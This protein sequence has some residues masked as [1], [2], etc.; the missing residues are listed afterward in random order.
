MGVDELAARTGNQQVMLQR[1][2]P[3]EHRVSRALR[4]VA[5]D[6]PCPGSEGQSFGDVAVA[7][8]ITDGRA[9]FAPDRREGGCDE[10]DAIESRPGVAPVK[11][12]A[13]ADKAQSGAGEC[14]SLGAH[15]DAEDEVG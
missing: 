11:A 14:I 6:Q 4:L 13:C 10:A 2:G 15:E 12:K 1:P 7:Q 8:T 3:C 5:L 9:K